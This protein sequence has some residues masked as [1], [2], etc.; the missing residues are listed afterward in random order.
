MRKR[1]A[2]RSTAATYPVEAS[3]GRRSDVGVAEVDMPDVG[4]LPQHGSD[5]TAADPPGG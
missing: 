5:V 3:K 2:V 4:Q 1:M